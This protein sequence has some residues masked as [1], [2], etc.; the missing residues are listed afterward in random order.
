MHSWLLGSGLGLLLLLQAPSG[1]GILEAIRSGDVAAVERIVNENPQAVGDRDENRGTPLHEAAAK[2][3]PRVASLLIEAGAPLSPSDDQG[4]TPLHRA[5][6]GGHGEVAKLL[7]A[8][9]ADVNARTK[10]GRTPLATVAMGRGRAD[11]AGLLIGAGAD[12]D[13]VDNLGGTPLTYAAFRASNDL[14]DVLLDHGAEVRTEGHL[15][16]EVFHRACAH[17][18][19]RLA[20]RMISR[21][22]DIATRNED[23]K[24]ALHSAAEGGSV[25]LI[26]LLTDRG[27]SPVSVDYAGA[28]PLHFSAGQGH[29]RA[30]EGLLERGAP[31]D[32]RDSL[33]RTAL[34]LAREGGHQKVVDLLVRRGADQGPPVFP[35]LEGDYIGQEPPGA[36]PRIFAPGLV[37]SYEP[38]HGCVTFSPEGDEVYWSIVDF[39]RRGSRILGMRREDG[40][41][42]APEPAPFGSSF[43]DDVPFFA[44]DGRRIYFLSTR[45]LEEGAD[46]G[47]ENIWFA[48]RDDDGWSP[49]RAV[50]PEVNS[51]DLHWQFSVSRNGNLYFASSAGGGRGL[52]DIYC[53][54]RVEGGFAAPENLGHSVNSELSDFAPLISPDESFLVFSSVNRPDGR[55]EVDLY[56]TF[57]D[58]EGE[59]SPARNLGPQI[60]TTAGELLTTLSPDGRYLFFSGR[61]DGRKGVFWVETRA[62]M[63]SPPRD[64]PP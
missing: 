34:H 42:T 59:W 32:A 28:T 17:G 18:Q 58:Q 57:R 24:N 51:M 49:S 14:V 9:G 53:A 64:N 4:F 35:L 5:V 39:A 6:S 21:G 47:K 41:W 38:V 62:L 11:L 63:A 48:R 56:I 37:S 54:R 8:R 7:I 44:P 13:P 12:V 25:E 19:V 29:T 26:V 36:I 33:G 23:G 3:L 20:E 22:L 52:N 43:S 45:P 27:L 10:R 61:R 46:P 16:I 2:G 31:L 50:G 40:R 55:G 15:W 30:T 1:S 60:N